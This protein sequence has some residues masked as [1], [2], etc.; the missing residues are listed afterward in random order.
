M[1]K[2]GDQGESLPKTAIE[3]YEGKLNDTDYLNKMS[4]AY[5]SDAKK[6][7]KSHF[8]QSDLTIIEQV[9][10]KEIAKTCIRQKLEEIILA[11]KK[12]MPANKMIDIRNEIVYRWLWE[13]YDIKPS[14]IPGRRYGNETLDVPEDF[15]EY[16]RRLRNDS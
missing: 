8:G 3:R 11:L 9:K 5:N 13:L 10:L 4:E 7:L 15:R 16:L 6:I 12:E 2:I 14:D 1:E